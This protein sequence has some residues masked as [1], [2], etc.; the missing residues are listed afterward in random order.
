MVRA[1]FFSGIISMEYTA[2]ETK[3]VHDWYADHSEGV[4]CLH[5]ACKEQYRMG[6]ILQASALAF[7]HDIPHIFSLLK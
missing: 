3:P 6:W 7:L 4:L 5:H 1:P 2:R